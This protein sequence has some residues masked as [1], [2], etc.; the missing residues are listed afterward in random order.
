M[1]DSYWVVPDDT[2]EIYHYYINIIVINFGSIVGN[3]PIAIT[4][5]SRPSSSGLCPDHNYTGTGSFPCQ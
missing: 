2:S 4:H 3:D 5:V 1:S